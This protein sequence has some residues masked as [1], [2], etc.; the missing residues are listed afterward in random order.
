[1]PDPLLEA[2]ANLHLGM[3]PFA[4]KNWRCLVRDVADKLIAEE[5]QKLLAVNR[6]CTQNIG[7]QA[8]SYERI[9]PFV[10]KVY[11]MH[12]DTIKA[13]GGWRFIGEPVNIGDRDAAGVILTELQESLVQN[14]HWK[15]S[16]AVANRVGVRMH[17]PSIGSNADFGNLLVSK[18][19]PEQFGR[20]Q[21]LKK[22]HRANVVVGVGEMWM[23]FVTSKDGTSV[24]FATKLSLK[25]K[26]LRGK[27]LL[28]SYATVRPNERISSAI[29]DAAQKAY[30]ECFP[31]YVLFLQEYMRLCGERIWS[32]KAAPV[33]G[34]VSVAPSQFLMI[35]NMKY[36]SE[37]CFRSVRGSNA[38]NKYKL[39]R[40]LQDS[41]SLW[42]FRN[43][44]TPTEAIRRNRY[45]MLSSIYNV[46]RAWG[47]TLKP[48]GICAT[49][50][51]GLLRSD[52]RPVYVPLLEKAFGVTSEKVI[53]GYDSNAQWYRDVCELIG[54]T[55]YF[56]SDADFMILKGGNGAEHFP[57]QLS[58]QLRK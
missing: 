40:D 46:G 26:E 44:K 35:G 21:F 33:T 36:D 11:E 6:W 38:S 10:K 27:L 12:E 25:D 19:A 57:S 53:A 9:T 32:L 52:L 16:E 49:N 58:H 29:L 14:K 34:V 23:R 30:G 55:I 47:F 39:A 37:S 5:V 56:N 28:A 54:Q 50:F 13:W 18:N 17:L 51:Y 41:F 43:K 24:P 31:E 7:G 8:I 15:A 4:P 1:M 3:S 2:A 48:H 20:R 45:G 22:D 42:F